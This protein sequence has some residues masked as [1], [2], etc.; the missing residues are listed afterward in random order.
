MIA[1]ELIAA[2][3]SLQRRTV[4]LTEEPSGE[5]AAIWYGNRSRPDGCWLTIA[6]RFIP[7]F[8]G[9][10]WLSVFTD[11]DECVGGRTEI[12]P[13]LLPSSGTSLFATEIN[14]LPPVD[15]LYHR[16]PPAIRRWLGSHG[17][18]P[19]WG[20]NDKFPG[21][22][23]V[24]EYQSIWFRECP[25]YGDRV[26]ATLGGWHLAWPDSD[27]ADSIDRQ[28]IVNTFMDSEPWVEVWREPSGI[29]T[30]EQRIT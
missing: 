24:R 11:D 1:D 2:G 25:L 27:W 29:L 15:V 7:S 16:G 22:E 30:V 14:V 28:L 4:A 10:G 8:S 20:F 26:F 21:S 23:A 3:R 19:Q 5:T 9:D 18:D 12:V 17:Y 13:K 6:T